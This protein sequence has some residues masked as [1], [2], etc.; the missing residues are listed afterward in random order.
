[1]K[2]T[3]TGLSLI[4][5][6]VF[7][8]V[9][10]VPAPALAADNTVNLTLNCGGICT[11]SWSWYQGGTSGTLLSSGSI[12]GADSTTTG[13]TV[14]PAAADTVIIVLEQQ[15]GKEPCGTSQTDSFPPGSH[16]NFT[17]KLKEKANAYHFGCF[18]T[19]S[20]KS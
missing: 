20:M 9:A 11:G 17:V 16:I 8:V 1:M 4:V 6:A 10:A 14:Q 13:T 15:A 18:D 2:R 7:G 5:A 19:F 12:S 3:V